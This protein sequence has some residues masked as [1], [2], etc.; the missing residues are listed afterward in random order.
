MAL[1]KRWRH[2][3]SSVLIWIL[4]CGGKRLESIANCLSPSHRGS[5]LAAIAAS[6]SPM[7][8]QA[9]CSVITAQPK[10]TSPHGP[11]WLLS[12][13]LLFPVSRTQHRP[14]QFLIVVI[15]AAAE[16]TCHSCFPCGHLVETLK[17][18][19]PGPVSTPDKTAKS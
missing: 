13:Y 10:A 6:S 18:K 5:D 4:K 12:P 16:Q 9:N 8:S 11:L 3:K 14:K 19:A 17:S 15:L 2:W 7:P 1:Y